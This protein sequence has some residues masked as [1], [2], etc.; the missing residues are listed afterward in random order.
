MVFTLESSG[1]VY[2]QKPLEP[3]LQLLS[4]SLPIDHPPQ[5]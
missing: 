4:V 2:Q 1:D 3:E 5:L